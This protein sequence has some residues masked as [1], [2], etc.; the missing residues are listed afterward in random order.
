MAKKRNCDDES[1]STGLESKKITGQEKEEG[2]EMERAR[3]GKAEAKGQK[4]EKT[5]PF[6]HIFKSFL[7]ERWNTGTML[8]CY[9]W[10]CGTLSSTEKGTQK[11]KG[12]RF[13]IKGKKNLRHSLKESRAIKQPNEKRE[14]GL[15]HI[16]YQT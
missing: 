14:W 10:Y 16:L 9:S 12:Q 6:Q 1:V 13:K 7:G 2:T 3:K 8:L 11:E 4:F 15:K 5:G